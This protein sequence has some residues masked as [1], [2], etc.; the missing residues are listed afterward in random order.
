MTNEEKKSYNKM[1]E[2]QHPKQFNQFGYYPKGMEFNPQFRMQPGYPIQN[3]NIPFNMQ[4]GNQPPMAQFPNQPV[5]GAQF[6]PQYGNPQ[7]G[8]P[9][10][11]N[12][13]IPPPPHHRIN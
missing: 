7:I 9:Q 11:R 1:K 8:Q 13:Q 12:F 2:K 5:M 6:N 4:Y 10:N 3:Q